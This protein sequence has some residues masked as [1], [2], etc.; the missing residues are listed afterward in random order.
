[1]IQVY[2]QGQPRHLFDLLEHHAAGVE[3]FIAPLALV[4]LDVLGRDDAQHKVHLGKGWNSVNLY[5]ASGDT[6][7]LRARQTRGRYDHIRVHRG[8][9]RPLG[10][11]EMEIRGPLDIER[12]HRKLS[13]WAGVP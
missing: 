3:D 9:M 1:M 6:I 7:A 8:S 2:G 10:P 13:R 12:F 11:L 4:L 5:L